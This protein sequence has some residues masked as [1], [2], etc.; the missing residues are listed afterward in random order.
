MTTVTEKAM[1]ASQSIKRWGASKHDKEITAQVAIDNAMA[2]EWGRYSKRLVAK[3]SLEK[4]SE[5][6]TRA[7]HHHYENTL[8]WLD[9]GAR[10]LPSANYFDYM[11]A[12][13]E[14]KRSFEDAVS[15]FISVY[16]SLI[17]NAKA[18]LGAAFKSDDYPGANEIA[19]KFGMT[20]GI[21][22]LPDGSDFRVKLGEAEEERIREAIEARTN[23]AVDNAMTSLWQ[24]IHDH[25]SHMAERLRAYDPTAKGKDAGLF[26]D[27]LVTNLRELVTVLPKMNITGSNSLETFRDRI[28]Q[29]LCQFDAPAL[30]DDAKL[31]DA[32]AAKAEAILAEVSDFI[33]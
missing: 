29:E 31:R 32:T 16:P 1:L 25:V 11:Q 19:G 3:E 28:E 2:A 22:P 24:G 5:I 17:A 20:I 13:N 12:Q 26:R 6:A 33:A 30:R 9:D 23:E 21:I 8:P 7:R 18:Q 14:F 4:I 15:D 10:I 27:S